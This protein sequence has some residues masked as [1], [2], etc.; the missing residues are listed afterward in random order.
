ME[1]PDVITLYNSLFTKEPVNFIPEHTVQTNLQFTN[2]LIREPE[3]VSIIRPLV[4]YIYDISPKRFYYLLFLYVPKREVAP[5]IKRKPP[6][7][8]KKQCKVID[9]I[10]EVLGWSDSEYT[11]MEDIVNKTILTDKKYWEQEFGMR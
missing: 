2:W 1:F 7:L 6:K 3:L 10:K 5:R 9:K 4:N 11:K 8:N